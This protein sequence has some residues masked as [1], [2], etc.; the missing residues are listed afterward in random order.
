MSTRHIGAVIVRLAAVFIVV[1]S[2]Q[3]LPFTLGTLTTLDDFSRIVA[4]S[5]ALNALLPFAIAWLLWKFPHTVAGGDSTPTE[6]ATDA[7]AVSAVLMQTGIALLG[8]YAVVFGVIEIA[9]FET[10]RI[11]AIKV[12]DQS[13]YPAAPADPY[14]IGQRVS[15]LLQVVVGLALILGRKTVAG[16]LVYLKTAGTKPS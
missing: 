12:A 15:Y 3:K 2:L 8:L 16:W 6:S 14:F 11:V 10:Q 7:E 9:F 4:I 1:T 13:G 5:F